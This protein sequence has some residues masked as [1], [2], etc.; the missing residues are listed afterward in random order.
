MSAPSDALHVYILALGSNRGSRHGRTPRAML[1]VA[2]SLLEHDGVAVVATAPTFNTAPV[3]PAKRRF[4]NSAVLV[5]TSLEPLALLQRLK[6]IEARLG[7]RPGQ[8]WS[9]RPIDIDIILWSGG[10]WS[11]ASL[12]IPHSSFRER[13]FVLDPVAKLA[14]AW[15]DPVTGLRVRHL[16]ARL[17][18]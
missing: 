11:D 2:R 12:R 10:P 1:D 9:N 17:R 13:H 5:E 16:R 15:R 3:G 4:A 6:S 18:R 8:R 7:R 14:P